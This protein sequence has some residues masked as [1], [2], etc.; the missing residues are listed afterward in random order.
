MTDAYPSP[1]AGPRDA[2]DEQTPLTQGERVIDTFIAPTKTF[3]DIRRNRSWWLPM[4]IL[5]AFSYLFALTAM[6]HVGP[7][8]LAE[9]AL[10][11]NPSQNERLQQATPE[12]RAQTL[13]ITATIMQVSFFGSPLLV[14]VSSALGALLL[15]VGFNFILGGS[16]TFSGMFAVMIFAW[17]PSI[18]RSILS[19]AMLFLGDPESFNIN[20]PIGTNPGFYMGAN[21]SAFLKAVLGSLDIFSI[22]I[23]VLMAVGGAIVARVKIRSGVI[24]VFAT[25]LIVVLLRAA[26]AA[27]MS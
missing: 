6:S 9:S 25:W 16:A 24:L 18:L 21:S 19:T 15:W 8:R 20:D 12:Q 3:A 13:R 27:A 22:W 1:A 10:R 7:Q 23:L 4:L 5:A 11:N 17:L 2:F 26:A 14:L